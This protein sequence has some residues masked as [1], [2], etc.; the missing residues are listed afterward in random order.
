MTAARSAWAEDSEITH[1]EYFGINWQHWDQLGFLTTSLYADSNF[2]DIRSI[3]IG[4]YFDHL[5]VDRWRFHVTM[6]NTKDNG[7]Q[8]GLDVQKWFFN[9]YRLGF[10]YQP[11]AKAKTLYFSGSFFKQRLTL[12]T[13]YNIENEA[14]SVS[15]H[16]RPW[17]STSI[18]GTGQ[19][20]ADGDMFLTGGLT[21]NFVTG[22]PPTRSPR[23]AKAKPVEW[24]D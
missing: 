24:L 4:H 19:R 15:P 12:Y 3:G 9:R 2:G 8:P 20:Y 11:L 13:S 21:I 14:L 18:Y 17:Q 7:W 1:N 16:Y 22:T 6:N 5:L 23:K 10:L